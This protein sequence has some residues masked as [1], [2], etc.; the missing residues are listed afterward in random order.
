[1]K[2]PQIYVARKVDGR[3]KSTPEILAEVKFKVEA[4]CETRNGIIL[5]KKF[6]DTDEAALK[7]AI[8]A[9]GY[10]NIHF[11]P[12]P[13]ARQLPF[14][15]SPMR[16][17]DARIEKAVETADL[18]YFKAKGIRESRFWFRNNV[19]RP[20][21]NFTPWHRVR[22]EKILE[23]EKTVI[24]SLK[25][26]AM[27]A[28]S[29]YNVA[30]GTTQGRP[31]VISAMDN[32]AGPKSVDAVSK[33]A[34]P[35]DKVTD[36]LTEALAHVPQ[37]LNTMYA[38]MGVL[39]KIGTQTAEVSIP[40]RCDM[41]YLG[42]SAGTF[43]E[44]CKH[45]EVELD[46]DTTVE[47]MKKASQK[48]IHS[49][50]ATLYSVA[51][52]LAGHDPI[53]S[54]FTQNFKNEYYTSVGEKQQTVESWEK[55][56]A[57][58]RTYEI[59]NE[60]FILLER[61]SQST[62]K[63]LEMGHLISVGMKWSR[64]GTDHLA[65]RL[66]VK[67]GE[68]WKR[69]FGDGDI[70][71]LDQSIHYIF[72]QLFYQMAGVFLDKDHPQY[73]EMMRIIDYVARTVS[74]RV[75]RFFGK[76]WAL[77]VGKMPSGCWMTSHGDSWIVLLW[78]FIFGI[79]QIMRAAQLEREKMEANLIKRIIL[80]I[81]Y[82]DDHIQSTDRDE[83]ARY[84]NMTQFAQWCK[85]YLQVEL[86]DVRRDVAFTVEARN[87]YKQTQGI[88]YLKHFNVRNRQVDDK[89]PNYLP[90]RNMCDYQV[91]SVWG[92]ECKDRDIFDFILSLIGHSY[93]TYASNYDAYLW[94]QSAYIGS[95]HVIGEDVEK[96]LG[97]VMTRS[98]TNADFVKK[99]RQADIR[100][101]D[102]KNGFPLWST[103]VKKNRKDDI[104]HLHTKNDYLNQ[105][106]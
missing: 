82:G 61:I 96:T 105:F 43:L 67:H 53:Q 75:V 22:Q 77:V 7:F 62:R 56:L 18:M 79:M 33:H 99:M 100:L 65:E 74:A 83:T 87:G 10:T 84:F 36:G 26:L 45:Y 25:A 51:S 104:Y 72:L 78:F 60:F 38:A 6:G 76:L 66:G 3:L 81:V 11:I 46:E 59:P 50:S 27:R 80:M 86:R 64:G 31:H 48:K 94:L 8:E 57:K 24:P 73:S 55:Y 92:R 28:I 90:Y 85:V 97:T 101:E 89:Q 41:M 34:R 69:I 19:W 98:H 47:I 15:N 16:P 32:L 5:R 44:S 103:L 52:F 2:L 9:S 1:M 58:V 106:A 40:A 71:G 12:S 30:L 42:A 4:C 63:L 93:G 23:E 95:F 14:R 54:L 39:D 17:I 13:D 35:T 29:G 102:L 49:H 21:L 20:Y 70:S 37:A 68:E 91:K 88:V